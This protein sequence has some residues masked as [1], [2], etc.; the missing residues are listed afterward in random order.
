MWLGGYTC[1]N[2]SVSAGRLNRDWGSFD[3]L[4]RGLILQALAL[5]LRNI[6]QCCVI[7]YGRLVVPSCAE[8]EALLGGAARISGG[9]NEG[10]WLSLIP[11]HPE[12]YNKIIRART[13]LGLAYAPDRSPRDPGQ[14]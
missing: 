4:V 8:L 14:G 2:T 5:Q 11:R 13:L 7:A 12:N 9:P 1:V 10:S 6:L 3:K